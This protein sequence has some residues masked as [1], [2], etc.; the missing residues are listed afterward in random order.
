MNVIFLDIDGVLN[1]TSSF[2]KGTNHSCWVIDPLLVARL[3]RIVENVDDL[4]IVLSSSWRYAEAKKQI[5]INALLRE[6]GFIGN[7]VVERTVLDNERVEDGFENRGD[8][9]QLWLT[10]HPEVERFVILDDDDDMCHLMDHLVQT[11]FENGGLLA[12]H[13]DETIKILKG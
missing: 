5:D 4:T 2:G 12:E 13:V 10:N 9:I 1:C 6:Q 8:E 7:P 3:N 11:S